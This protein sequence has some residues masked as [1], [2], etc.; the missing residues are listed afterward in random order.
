MTRTTV[1][2]KALEEINGT[3]HLDSATATPM[4][5]AH[6][7]AVEAAVTIAS[8]F[9]TNDYQLEKILDQMARGAE[10]MRAYKS[11]D[12][13]DQHAAVEEAQDAVDKNVAMAE[14]KLAGAQ[15][16]LELKQCEERDLSALL[17]AYATAYEAMTGKKWTAPTP[18]STAPQRNLTPMERL[19]ANRKRLGK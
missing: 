15:R 17:K 4:H 9:G 12:V 14:T 19:E 2:T 18:K 13:T 3:T 8:L 10:Y 1:D 16:M 7:L 6:D 5:N 11:Q